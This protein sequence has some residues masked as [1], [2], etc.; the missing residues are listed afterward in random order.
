MNRH[1]PYVS[2]ADFD[3]QCFQVSFSTEDPGDDFDLSAPP[4]PLVVRR[5]QSDCRFATSSESGQ[6]RRGQLVRFGGDA[7]VG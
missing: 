4:G 2:I 6:M 7:A 3:D 5:P 1:A